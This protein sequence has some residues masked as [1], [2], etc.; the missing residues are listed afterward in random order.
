MVLRGRSGQN[1]NG[2]TIASGARNSCRS[3]DPRVC[4][5]FEAGGGGEPLATGG[6]PMRPTTTTT[7]PQ[8]TSTSI[9]ILKGANG[10]SQQSVDDRVVV[11]NLVGLTQAQADTALTAVGL[12][13]DIAGGA[14]HSS[15][16]SSTGTVVA[17]APAPGSQVMRGS[18]IDLTVSGY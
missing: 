14:T 3:A 1:V 7:K 17:Q 16:T 4:A 2:A 18:V 8:P 10:A 15:G 12:G 13:S 5:L 6:F 9:V 11:P